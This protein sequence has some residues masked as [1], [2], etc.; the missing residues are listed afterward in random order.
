VSSRIVVVNVGAVVVVVV[1]LVVLV[2]IDVVVVVILVV[3]VAVFVVVFVVILFVLRLLRDDVG[4]VHCCSCRMLLLLSLH[5][6]KLIQLRE[7]H[8][9]EWCDGK[10]L[11]R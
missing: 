7:D 6:R 5:V 2:V 4:V 11:V 3:V 1:V 8:E 10:Y 9:T